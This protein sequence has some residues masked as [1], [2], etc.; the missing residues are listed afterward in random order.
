MSL[1]I[2]GIFVLEKKNRRWTVSVQI[3]DKS[4][5][6]YPVAKTVGTSFEPDEIISLRK[7]AYAIIPTLIGQT[8]IDSWSES[9]KDIVRNLREV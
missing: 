4:I 9:T 6:G 8:T 2:V 3:I 1:Y 7:K 5:G